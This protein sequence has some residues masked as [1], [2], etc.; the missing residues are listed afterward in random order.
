MTHSH[1]W[2]TARSKLRYMEIEEYSSAGE[3]G[4]NGATGKSPTFCK[5]NNFGIL[6][7]NKNSFHFCVKDAFGY[8]YLHLKHSKRLSASVMDAESAGLTVD[9]PV[10]VGN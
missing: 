6:K 9:A 5:R 10:A 1:F 2:W 8:S 7:V 4:G 3:H